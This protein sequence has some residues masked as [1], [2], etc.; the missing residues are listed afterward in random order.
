MCV[1]CADPKSRDANLLVTLERAL[2]REQRDRHCFLIR[3]E[4]RAAAP[5]DRLTSTV[6]SCSL[7]PSRL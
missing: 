3:A 5:A 4:D 2:D 7:T 6:R 1:H